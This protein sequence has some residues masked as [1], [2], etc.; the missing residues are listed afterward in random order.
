M[1]AFHLIP[2]ATLSEHRSQL[3]SYP[4]AGVKCPAK[5]YSW[6]HTPP[7]FVLWQCQFRKRSKNGNCI[8][9]F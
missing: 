9:F 1:K 2:A 4:S 7:L 5:T 8:S 3:F 6:Q